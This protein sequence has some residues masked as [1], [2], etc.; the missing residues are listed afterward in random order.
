MSRSTE[1]SI[2]TKCGQIIDIVVAARRPLAFSDIVE[3]TGFVKSSCHRVLAVLQGEGL[4]AYDKA[5]RTYRTGPRLHG[6]TWATWSNT[7]L[8]RI[9]GPAMEDLADRTRMNTALSILDGETI[10]YIRTCNFFN[11]RFASRAGDRAPLHSTAAGKVFLANMSPSRQQ[12]SLGQLTLE[13]F[14]EHTLVTFEALLAQFA[15][16][17]TQGFAV[18]RSEE[19]LQVTGIA[20]P[21]LDA[22]DQNIACLSLWSVKDH[23]APEDV[24][25]EAPRLVEAA[26]A[27]SKDLGNAGAS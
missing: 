3:Q 25:A 21:V 8:Q 20:A 16:I 11:V 9:A 4:I 15:D 23:H 18:A 10:I 19:A 7:D 5:T 17:R 27:V 1:S 13:R 6:W 22:G 2:V 12:A 26:R 24:I 14:T